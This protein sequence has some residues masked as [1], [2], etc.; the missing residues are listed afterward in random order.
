MKKIIPKMTA[1]AIL[2][3]AFFATNAMSQQTPSTSPS[4]SSMSATSAKTHSQR[5]ADAVEKRITQLHAELKITDQQTRPWDNFAQTMRDNA[6]K[7]AQAFHDRAQK[8]PTMNADDAMKSYADITQ[9]H[10]DNMKK[11]ASAWSDLYAVLS[12]DQKQVADV[13]YR[14]ET[15]KSHQH[16][17][18]K[19]KSGAPASEASAPSN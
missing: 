4:T 19:P 14:N 18:H 9:L 3:F 16:S 2:I 11:L 10:A 15:L 7:A 5:K 12:T 8:L 1:P 13:L 6:Q 17:N